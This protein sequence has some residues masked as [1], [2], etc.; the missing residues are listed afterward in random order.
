MNPDPN[1]VEVET[2]FRWIQVESKSGESGFV[3][4][5]QS[6]TAA[7]EK[8]SRKWEGTRGK[9]NQECHLRQALITIFDVLDRTVV[10]EANFSSFNREELE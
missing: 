6:F 1:N 5:S 2:C 8:A 4:A 9:K 7:L 3:L 10:T